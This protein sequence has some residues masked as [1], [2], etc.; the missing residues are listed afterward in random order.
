[1]LT[2][3]L[4]QYRQQLQARRTAFDGLDAAIT[5][6]LQSHVEK[7]AISSISDYIEQ[8]AV[9]SAL[10]EAVL[11]L[12][13]QL[14]QYKEELVTAKTTFNDLDAVLANELQSHVEEKAISSISDY[15]EQSAVES[16]LTEAVL[17]LTEQLSQYKEELITAKTTF[18]DLDAVLANELQSHVEEKA[19]S[20]ISDYIEQSAVE[21]ALTEAV[22]EL[23]EQ[24]SQ[25][26]EELITAK[27]TFNDLD[28]VL[29]NELQSHV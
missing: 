23:T 21:S 6:E 17:E 13:E 14:S 22:L 19:I 18:N 15:I 24:L 5:Q 11:E 8:S 29:A 1:Q 10:T 28:A 9:E 7:R 4:S 25:Y 20:S 27:T 2:E 26:K 3:Q 12:T 16:A